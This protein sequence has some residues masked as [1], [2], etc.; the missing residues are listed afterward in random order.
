MTRRRRGAPELVVISWR[1]IPAQVTATNADSKESTVLS[2]RF[3][4][5]IDRA[6]AVAG[7]TET[8]AYVNEWRRTS[9]PLTAD[10][11]GVEVSTVAAGIEAGYPRDRLEAIVQDGGL[12]AAT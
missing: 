10:D 1:D 3:Q 4:V 12:D 9:H 8:Q 11:L 6:A 5:A 7:L 2:D